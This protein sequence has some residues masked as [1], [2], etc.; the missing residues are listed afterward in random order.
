MLPPS[1]RPTLAGAISQ[2]D[3]DP[4]NDYDVPNDNNDKK[5]S[6]YPSLL[7]VINIDMSF[8]LTRGN[9]VERR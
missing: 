7:L 8:G 5:R 2:P 3:V 4:I 6:C 9:D 1:P